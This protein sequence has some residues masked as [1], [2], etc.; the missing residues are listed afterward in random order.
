[1]KEQEQVLERLRNDPAYVRKIIRLQLRL[2]QTSE[3][4]FRF[5]E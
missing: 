5:E 4:I 2:R 3:L 1:M